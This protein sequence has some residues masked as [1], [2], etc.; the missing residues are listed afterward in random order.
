MKRLLIAFLLLIPGLL[1]AGTMEYP[2]ARVIDTGKLLKFNPADTLLKVPV[3]LREMIS[4]GTGKTKTVS[5]ARYLLQLTDKKNGLQAARWTA[6]RMKKNLLQVDLS[7]FVSKY[8][9]ETEKNLA[10][11]FDRAE[12]GNFILFFDE[13]DALFGKRSSVSES[14]DRYANQEVSYF[15][16]RVEKYTGVVLISCSGDDCLKNLIIKNSKQVN[17]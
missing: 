12:E 2:D 11:L 4:T 14:H 13:A 17:W 10:R 1:M 7:G 15:I 3:S 8:I 5:Q 6:A 9:G 16:Q